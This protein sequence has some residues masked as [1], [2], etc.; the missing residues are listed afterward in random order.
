MRRLAPVIAVLFACL[1]APPAMGA[2]QGVTI[3]NFAYSPGTVNVTIGD[4]VTWTWSGP[5]T[6][7]SVTANAGQAESFN[8]DPGGPPTSADH[9]PGA[10]FPHTFTHAGTFRYFCTVH[11]FMT[12]KVV[13]AGP[14]GA[15]VT[16]PA[17]S[18]LKA[19]GSTK[20]VRFT[21][22][23]AAAVKVAVKPLSRKGRTRTVSAT[24][25]QGTNRV[26][27]RKL[28]LKPGR[29]RATVRATDAAGNRS[30][31]KSTTFRVP[32]S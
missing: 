27:V 21:L 2:S 10:T 17:I 28:K 20:R 31:A 19:S 29:Y 16:P 25:R 4:T 24:G 13:V 15:D 26:S 32:A 23:E 6:N 3:A 1:L 5:D 9:L 14:G 8:S 12:G 18:A 11:S 30:P 22:S 7:H